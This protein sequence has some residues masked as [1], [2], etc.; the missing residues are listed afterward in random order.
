[1]NK[2]KKEIEWY[3]EINV[4]LL[5]KKNCKICDSKNVGSFK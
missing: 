1:M 3:F 2:K 5:I 4:C